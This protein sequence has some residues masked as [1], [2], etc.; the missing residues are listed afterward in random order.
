MQVGFYHCTRARPAAVVPVLSEKAYTAGHRLLIHVPDAGERDAVDENL[1]TYN[2]GSFLPH[3]QANAAD[4]GRQPILLSGDIAPA[5]DA[6]VLIALG[7]Q[8]PGDRSVFA[9]LLYLFDGGDED[10]L[11]A[12]RAH[13]KALK[14]RDDVEAVYWAQGER[15]WERQTG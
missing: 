12:A 6:D 7:A 11:K 9:R 1:W 8:L 2:A 4:A 5:N 15:G 14:E 3:G 10:A 13:W